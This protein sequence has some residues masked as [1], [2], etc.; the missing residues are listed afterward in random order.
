LLAA[1]LT[2]RLRIKVREELGGSYGP[3]A[4]NIGSDTFPGYGYM[5]ASIDVAPAEAEKISNLVWTLLMSSL[6]RASPTTSWRGRVS[7]AHGLQGIASFEQLLDFCGRPGPGKTG[8][9]RLDPDAIRRC[10]DHR[11]RDQR[12]GEKISEPRS[13]FARDY[14]TGDQ[15]LLHRNAFR[16]ITRLVHVAAELHRE[17]V[18]KELQRNNT[19]N[20]TDEIR[21]SR[22]GDDIV[23]DAFQLFAAVTGS[24]GDDRAFP[25]ADL[26]NVVHILREHCVVGRNEN[27]GQIRADKGD[28][29][30]LELGAGM[31]LREKVGDL[32]QFQGRF[33]RDR[34]IELAPEKKNAVGGGVLLRD[35]LHLIAE[36]ENFRDLIRQL[37]Q[38]FND[39]SSFGSREMPHPA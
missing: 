33:H 37:F 4:E 12:D 32:F 3:Q 6:K 29:P 8:N 18:G 7:P 31:T 39:A 11:H 2:D 21:Y 9:A 38:R 23:G 36:F 17:V 25:R 28:D 35:S 34:V 30:V 1:I 20:R 24:D 22:E 16:E 15:R 13:R 26:L 14:F 19:Q 10:G 5:A 27:R